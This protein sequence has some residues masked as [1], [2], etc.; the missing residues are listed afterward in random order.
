M[1]Q[2]MSTQFRDTGGKN[3]T[4]FNRHVARLLIHVAVT[5]AGSHNL[6]SPTIG[7]HQQFHTAPSL[8]L[9][10]GATCGQRMQCSFKTS[11]AGC[12]M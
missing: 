2:L 5:Q 1:L 12:N 10:V 8:R 9:R 4:Y 6:W 3:L 7:E 11:V